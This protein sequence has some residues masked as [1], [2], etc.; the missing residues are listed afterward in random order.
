VIDFDLHPDWDIHSLRTSCG[1]W[2]TRSLLRRNILKFIL[3]GV[4]SYD[5]SSVFIQRGDL[6][7]LADDRMEIY[8]YTHQ[9]STVFLRHVPDNISIE[10][11]RYP[12][13]S[14][15]S[16]NELRNKNPVELF[17]HILN[18]LPTKNVY[19]TIDKDC[20]TIED[21][22]TNWEEG[23]MSLDELLVLLKL[24]REHCEIVGADVVGDYS[25]YA[26]TEGFLKRAVSYLDHPKRVKARGIPEELVTAANEK[27]NL[28]ILEILLGA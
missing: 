19:L 14:R 4:S 2:V 13:F 1:S 15:I 16:W 25:D 7:S 3:V 18:R 20:L 24:V 23:F 11:K 9:P 5:I 27:T 10:V 22:L 17:I 26:Q 8:P 12:F 21:A 6:G 28:K